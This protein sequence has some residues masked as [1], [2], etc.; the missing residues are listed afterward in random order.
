MKFTKTK[1][2]EFSVEA[3]VIFYFYLLENYTKISKNMLIAFNRK[4]GI[5]VVEGSHISVL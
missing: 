3:K 1:I 2:M 5:K 4:A